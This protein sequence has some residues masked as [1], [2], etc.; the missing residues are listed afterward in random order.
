MT[1]LGHSAGE[2]GFAGTARTCHEE[3]EHVRH[4]FTWAGAATG[5]ASRESRTL[6]RSLGTDCGIPKPAIHVPPLAKALVG[7]IYGFPGISSAPRRSGGWTVSKGCGGFPS[8]I[9]FA[10]QV[11]STAR[12]ALPTGSAWCRFVLMSSAGMFVY[13]MALVNFPADPPRPQV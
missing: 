2:G 12:A 7:Q 1:P 3:H 11:H 8:D 10:A 5:V 13:L 9:K 6:G 4:P